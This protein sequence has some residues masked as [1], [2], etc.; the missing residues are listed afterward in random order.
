LSQNSIPAPLLNYQTALAS[1]SIT[2]AMAAA[3]SGVDPYGRL[4]AGIYN[5]V[6]KVPTAATQN[7]AT[8][9]A[10][11]SQGTLTSDN[12]ATQVATEQQQASQ[13]NVTKSSS[14]L[15]LGAASGLDD[16]P[17]TSSRTLIG[18]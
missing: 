14:A 15:L 1:P 18:S 11:P 16:S 9:G 3:N 7:P 12:L 8:A 4:A 5:D 17:N 2:N 6:T 10:P 13:E